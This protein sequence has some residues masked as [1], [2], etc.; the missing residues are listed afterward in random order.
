MEDIAKH[1]KILAV[2]FAVGIICGVAIMSVV[3]CTL[4]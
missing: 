3:S 2:I 4:S 1:E